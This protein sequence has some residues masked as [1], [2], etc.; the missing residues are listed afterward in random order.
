[1]VGKYLWPLATSALTTLFGA[2]VLI[3]PFIVHASH[4]S[5]TKATVTDFWSGVGLALVGLVAFGAWYGALKR[6]MVQ[7]GLIEMPAKP[8][9]S[10]ASTPEAS[11]PS[12]GDDDLDR[13]L[14]PLAESVLRDLTEQLEAKEQSHT[15]GGG[16][17]A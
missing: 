8:E 5:W 12:G 4:G 7:K 10:E 2:G 9:P 13:L 3:W 1:M 17:L 16:S 15:S 11:A 14:R 6:D